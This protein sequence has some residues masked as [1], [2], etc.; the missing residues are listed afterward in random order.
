[1]KKLTAEFCISCVAFL[2]SHVSCLVLTRVCYVCPSSTLH[3]VNIVETVDLVQDEAGRW[4]EVMEV[5]LR[6]LRC[7]VSVVVGMLGGCV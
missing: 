6:S 1:V 2:L 4:C 3:H 5:R 7:F